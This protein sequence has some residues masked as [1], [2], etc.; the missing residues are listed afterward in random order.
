MLFK[1]EKMIIRSVLHLAVLLLVGNVTPKAQPTVSFCKDI[2][3]VLV[4]DLKPLKVSRN[5]DYGDECL[6]SFRT[7]KDMSLT[8][9]VNK[10]LSE[11]EARKEI[12][13]SYKVIIPLSTRERSDHRQK[14][15]EDGYW[16]EAIAV[17]GEPPNHAMFL[18]YK[19]FTITILSWDS[20][21]LRQTECILRRIRFEKHNK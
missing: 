3:Q 9:D 5:A 7:E 8:V 21:L 4:R 16:S 13:K 18:R 11:N 6:L 17:K 14:V 19:E 1:K 20:E 15:N 10:Y 12:K 2:E